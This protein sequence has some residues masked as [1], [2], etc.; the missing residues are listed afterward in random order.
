MSNRRGGDLILAAI[1]ASLSYVPFEF[2]AKIT[3][4]VCAF[5]FIVDPFAPLSR[6]VALICVAMVHW[7]TK[8]ERN[9]RMRMST[10]SEEDD[11]HITAGDS[12]S[13]LDEDKKGK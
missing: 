6:I 4:L 8:L 5:M 1:L 9:Y 12:K 7:L 13:R 10:E 11:K 2:V 3:L